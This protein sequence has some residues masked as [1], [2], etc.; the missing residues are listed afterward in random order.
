MKYDP[1]SMTITINREEMEPVNI[2]DDD[3][4]GW[5]KLQGHTMQI[6]LDDST[7]FEFEAYN[8]RQI[9]GEKK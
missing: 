1:E 7:G 2:G 5:E 3:S 8:I 4:D 6:W 9:E